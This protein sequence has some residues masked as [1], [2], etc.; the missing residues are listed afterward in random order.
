MRTSEKICDVSVFYGASSCV[1]LKFWCGCDCCRSFAG[2]KKQKVTITINMA[3]GAKMYNINN[4]ELIYLIYGTKH[5]RCH[6]NVFVKVWN[7]NHEGTMVIGYWGARYYE[8]K[9]LKCGEHWHPC[10]NQPRRAD[11]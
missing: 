8:H 3:N 9:R 7:E 4:G 6:P 10:A 11:E 2:P 1:S 5:V